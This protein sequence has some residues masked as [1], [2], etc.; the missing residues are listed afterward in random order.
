MNDNFK[1]Y[2]LIGSEINGYFVVVT[3]FKI[4]QNDVDCKQSIER[5]MVYPLI[6]IILDYA[7]IDLK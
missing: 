3:C 1:V 6:C 5:F 2:G 7:S 4:N